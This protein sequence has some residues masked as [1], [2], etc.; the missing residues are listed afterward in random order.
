MTNNGIT[1]TPAYGKDY[2]TA[3]EALAAWN[4]GKD[5]IIQTFTHPYCGKP[6]SKRD[7]PATDTVYIRFCGTTKIVP[8][9]AEI[10]VD[11]I[12]RPNTQEVK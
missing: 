7:V 1:V 8:S 12:L 11:G 5:F 6:M 9:N 10:T 2:T 3:K 4:A